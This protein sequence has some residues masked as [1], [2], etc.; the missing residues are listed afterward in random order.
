MYSVKEIFL[1]LQG[2]GYHAGRRAVFVR[3]SGC[4]MWSGLERDR[5]RGPGPCSAWCDT[6]FVG[7]R[8]LSEDELLAKIAETWGAGRPGFLVFTGGEPALQ[9]TETLIERVHDHG[10]EIAIETNG[11]RRLPHN[12][13]RCWV[14]VSPKTPDLE[15]TVGHELKLVHPTLPPEQFEHL[16]FQHFF[17]QPKDGPDLR[18]NTQMTVDYILKNPKWRLSMQAHKLVGIP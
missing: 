2:E 13:W 15:I 3:F 6:D 5:N 4:N 10:F 7:G 9:L 16:R 1:T 14:T 18:A 8:S 11:S 17:L 12:R